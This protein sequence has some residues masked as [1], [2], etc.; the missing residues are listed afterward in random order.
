[1][2]LPQPRLHVTARGPRIPATRI[3][4]PPVTT[5]PATENAN[6][7]HADPA[8]LRVGIV[9]TGGISRSHAPGWLE[10]GAQL[11][12]FS[13]SGA[14]E[15]AEQFGARIHD[16][17]ESLLTAVDVVDICSPTPV[18]AE[19]VRAALDAGKD[20]VCEKPLALTAE[21]A[22]ELAARGERAGRLLLPAHV[23]LSFPEYAAAKVGRAHV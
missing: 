16:S 10:S 4:G 17:L 6:M 20:V 19:Q 5:P 21:D 2:A 14:P 23:E 12:C 11:H 15:F 22:Q 13:L 3:E 7:P 9:G 8:P 1:M 18:H